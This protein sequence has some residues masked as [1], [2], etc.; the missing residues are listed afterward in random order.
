MTVDGSLARLVKNFSSTQN[1][2]LRVLFI[3]QPDALRVGTESHKRVAIN[4][5]SLSC[6]VF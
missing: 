4:C 1:I 5:F 6:E 2:F 3:A